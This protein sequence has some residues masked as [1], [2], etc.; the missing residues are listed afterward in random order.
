MRAL[1]DATPR[2]MTRRRLLGSI[3][4]FT[5]LGAPIARAQTSGPIRIVVPFAAGGSV[6]TIARLVQPGLQQRLGA[7]VIVDNRV[8]ASGSVGAAAVARSAPDGT[9]Y[10]LCFDSQAINPSLFPNL[11]FDTEKDLDPVLLI[12]TGPHVICTHPSRPFKTFAD[13]V[14]AAKAKPD[15]ITC[16]NGGAGSLAHL[17]AVL[18][19]KHAGIRLVHV[20][21]R[22]GGPS[23]NDAVAG[24]VDLISGTIAQVAVQLQ[25]GALR[26]LLQT[27]PTRLTNL[28][29]VPT[30]IESGFPDFQAMTW[31]G[32][33]APARTPKTT[34]DRFGGALAAT[35]RDPPVM[36]RLTETLQIAP[37]L[38][39]PEELRR[40]LRAQMDLWGPVVR[41]HDIKA[42]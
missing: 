18:L 5:T 3:A 21:Y 36:K 38:G 29:D 22:G 23:L 26:P 30:A 20:F 7:T 2:G 8:G 16:S 34:I 19:A 31:W 39:G 1:L 6:D 25:S 17:T 4:V 40:F 14:A 9:T 11:P 24:H 35:L 32:T 10:L 27:G 42:E 37:L 33:F 15:T 41:E 13:M 12:G 28:P